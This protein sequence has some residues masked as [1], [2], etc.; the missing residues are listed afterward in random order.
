MDTSN[1]TENDAASLGGEYPISR[2]CARQMHRE[3]PGGWTQYP[4]KSGPCE[5]DCHGGS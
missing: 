5:C 3:C 1:I 4:E 2:R